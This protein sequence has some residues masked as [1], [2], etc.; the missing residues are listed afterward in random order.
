LGAWGVHGDGVRT[1]PLSGQPDV[2]T[3]LTPEMEQMV[4]AGI[5]AGYGRFVKLVADSRHQTPAAIDAIAQGRVW[6]GASAKANGLVD[7]FGTLDDAIAYA[8]GAAHLGTNDWHAEF[9]RNKPSPI[10][11]LIEQ[12]H[13]GDDDDAADGNAD[14]DDGAAVPHDL[15]GLAA[16]RQRAQLGAAFAGAARLL[17]GAGAQA[18]CLECTASLGAL[19]GGGQSGWQRG[20]QAHEGAGGWMNF[21]GVRWVLA[22]LSQGI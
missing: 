12:L 8:A 9:L 16:L 7:Q 11:Q 2:M 20:G 19:P 21:I 6:D 18:Y 14:R 5:E 17:D 4:Q 22:L 1:T 10:V 3:G 13:G 15:A